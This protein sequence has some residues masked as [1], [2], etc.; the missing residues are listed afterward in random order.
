MSETF[1]GV[2]PI[3]AAEPLRVGLLIGFP[4]IVL[5]LPQLLG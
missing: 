2:L 1:K 4:A 5:I 3:L